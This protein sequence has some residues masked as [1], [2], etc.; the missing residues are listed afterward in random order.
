M[1]HDRTDRDEIQL[2][3]QYLATMLGF[4]APP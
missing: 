4:S 1:S 3:Q 2:T